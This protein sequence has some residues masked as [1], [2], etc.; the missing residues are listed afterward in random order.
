MGVGD[1]PADHHNVRIEHA[2]CGRQ[3]V[4]QRSAGR[5]DD[6]DCVWIPG[7]YESDHV[8]GGLRLVAE[9]IQVADH[10]TSTGDGGE[11]ATRTATAAGLLNTGDL[12]MAD[13]A[14]RGLGTPE[15]LTV[16]D[17][18]RSDTRTDLDEKHL[19]SGRIDSSL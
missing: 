11:T 6:P 8:T 10:G 2:D 3:H 1:V 17:H 16:D 5:G 12:G 4:A 9:A 13:V 14:L 15:Q 7:P 19:M 18:R